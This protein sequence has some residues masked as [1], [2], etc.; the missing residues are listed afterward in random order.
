MAVTGSDPNAAMSAGLPALVAR[1]RSFTPVPLAVGFGVDNRTHFDF[2]TSAGADGVVIGSRVIKV[3]LEGS[4]T[5]KA[6]E[7]IE[8]FCR[9]I[10]LK[11]Q[12]KRPLGRTKINHNDD[13]AGHPSP[14][15]PIPPTNP[16]EKGAMQIKSGGK[17][18]SRFGIFGGAYVPEA[19]VDCLAELEAAYV[20]AS[21][22]PAFWKEFEDMYGYMNRPSEL[23]LAERLTEEMGGA[24]IWMK[25]VLDLI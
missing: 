13:A 23:Y 4:K 6:P 21:K 18:P 7:A 24:K 11:G 25:W 19:L 16:M 9:E 20:S 12:D 22:D 14:P 3:I 5:G 15:L 1:I 17:L 8:A 10:S 2:V